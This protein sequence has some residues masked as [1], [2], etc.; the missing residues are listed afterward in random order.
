MPAPRIGGREIEPYVG[1][2]EVS[3]QT[4]TGTE[5]DLTANI[6]QQVKYTSGNNLSLWFSSQQSPRCRVNRSAG[7]RRLK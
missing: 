1:R 6:V 4:Q 2:T 5:H 3:N 7:S